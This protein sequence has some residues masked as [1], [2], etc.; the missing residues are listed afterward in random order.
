M[1]KVFYLALPLVAAVC[2]SIAVDVVQADPIQLGATH[3]EVLP[4]L[5][6]QYQAGA[7]VDETAPAQPHLEWFPIP[8]W[9]AGTWQKQ[10]DMEDSAVNLQTGQRLGSPVFIRNVVSLSFGDQCDN[11]GTVWHAE[12]LPFRSDGYNGKMEDRRFV[13]QMQCVT[14]TAAQ[15][16]LQVRSFVVS[17]DLK[18]QKVKNSKQQEEIITFQPLDGQQIQTMSSTRDFSSTGQALMQSQSH[19]TRT[20]VAAFL[21]VPTLNGLD[22]RQSLA[23]YLVQHNWG[24]L[25]PQ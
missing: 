6:A 16:V 23:D 3:N 10:G 19:T 1:F 8:A 14:N 17:I 4:P 2:L 20:R 11:R 9:M 7:E 21:P 12:V 15:V 25:V 22:L 24:S 5:P 13:T 18:K